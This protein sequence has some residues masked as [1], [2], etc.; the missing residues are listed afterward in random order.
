[1]I[2][3][4][5]WNVR[6]DDNSISF[7]E[8]LFKSRNLTEND[9]DMIYNMD[10]IDI[11]DIDVAIFEITSAIN[12]KKKI[13]IFGDYDVDGI[14]STV[15]LKKFFNSI[16]YPVD[17]YIPNRLTEGYGISMN[18]VD[19]LIE[20]K[21]YDMIITVDN[22]IAAINQIEKLTNNGIKVIVT[23]HHECKE[24]LPNACAVIDCKRPDNNYPFRELCGAGIVLKLIQALSDELGLPKDSWRNY[25]EFAAIATIADVMPLINENRFI[26]KEG[27]NLIK[28]TSNKAILNLLRVSDKL[29]KINELIADDIGF[30]IA[31]LLNASSRIG[32]V[33]TAMNL[34]LS[35]DDEE[36]IKYSDELKSLNEQRKKIELEIFKEANKFLI[37]NYNFTSLNPIVVYGDNWNKGVIGIVASR[38]VDLYCK[39]VI[40]LSKIDNTLHGSCRTYGNINMIE[41]LDSAKEYII[42]YGGHEGAAGL[43]IDFDNIDKFI[44]KINKYASNNFSVSNFTPI[45]EADMSIKIEEI[46]VENF[47]YLNTLAPFG[48]SNVFPLFVLKDVEVTSIR[49]IGQKEGSENAHLKISVK[50]NN[51]CVSGVGF[52][53]SDFADIVKVGDYIDIMFKPGINEWQNEITAQMMISDIRCEITQQ[54]GVSVEEDAMYKEDEIPISEICMEYEMDI[55]NYIPS[56]DECYNSFRALC[57]IIMK[58][59]NG[60]LV[61]DLD[62]LCIV[63]NAFLKNV[64]RSNI[65][66]NPFKLARIIE[67]NQEAGYFNY[68]KM[69]FNKIILS[70]T[71]GQNIKRIS[72]TNVFK[73][74]ESEREYYNEMQREYED[75]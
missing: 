51:I 43:K 59:Q 23:D 75:D 63:I 21:K 61:A 12:N 17:Y 55:T 3:K 34:M 32:S 53:I 64:Y 41:M 42:E 31:P 65:I 18:T 5:D 28:K 8:R 47:E 46:T 6:I 74:L 68:K 10:Y 71:D 25:L 48:N 36:C 13:L 72:E 20:E 70:L 29:E 45:L 38:L 39:P 40:I 33:E 52:Y 1:M 58:Q 69:L 15:E 9:I 50:K 44:K 37:D 62:I 24:I 66:I 27:L 16:N 14:M 4:T 22:G 73:N 57:S 67:I 2:K 30:Y 11:N 35:N 54:D 26:V 19:K 56:V 49:K 7:K 60:V